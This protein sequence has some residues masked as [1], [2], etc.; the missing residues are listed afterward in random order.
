M[1]GPLTLVLALTLVSGTPPDEEKR[2]AP[3]EP[4]AETVWEFLADKY[5]ANGDGTITKT[6]YTGP[7]ERWKQ[8]DRD[9]SGAIDKAEIEERGRAKRAKPGKKRP[10]APKQGKKAP[11]FELEVLED[12][13]DLP[14]PGEEEVGEQGEPGQ[15]GKDKKEKDGD[16]EE[17]EKPAKPRTIA[18]ADFRGEKP[19]ALVFGSYT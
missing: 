18:L 16:R 15:K 11:L 3:E 10:V 13:G 2:P 8:L 14:K 1:H 6:E 19:V 9:G 12:L 17:A 7:E 4:T 5:D